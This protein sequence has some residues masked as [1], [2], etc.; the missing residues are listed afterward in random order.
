MVRNSANSKINIR[1]LFRWLEGKKKYPRCIE[2]GYKKC[3]SKEEVRKFLEFLQ[4]QSDQ[5]RICYLIMVILGIRTSEAISIRLHQIRGNRLV[6][7][8]RKTNKIHERI[9]P[10]YLKNIIYEYIYEYKGYF[11]E[12]YIFPPLNNQSRNLHLSRNTLCWVM[13]EFR[14][15]YKLNDWYYQRRDGNK[16]YRISPHTLRHAFTS[17]ILQETNDLMFVKDVV[18]WNKLQTVVT[19]AS[20]FKRIER[21]E[22][23]INK[24]VFI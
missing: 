18:G 14:D 7:K 13:K 16:L 15:K 11:R 19:Y 3:M 4:T 10:N 21:E 17:R 1:S 24:M 6:L 22:K 20:A 5:V 9:M 23:I 2:T 8:L 12:G